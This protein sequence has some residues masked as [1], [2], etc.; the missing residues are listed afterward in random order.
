MTG[1]RRRARILPMDE[2]LDAF[3]EHLRLTRGASEHTLR[4]YSS[5]VLA[6]IEFARESGGPVDQMLVRRYLARLHKSGL[7][8]SSM[9][10]KLAAIR[11]FYG[12]LLRRGVVETDP[13]EGVR[14]PRLPRGLP[15]TLLEDQIESLMNAPDPNTPLGLRDRAILE[16]LYATGLRV[17][18]LLGLT[19][20]DVNGGSD[21]IRVIGKRNK[22]RIVLLGSKARQALDAYLAYGRP[23]LAAKTPRS[24]SFAKEKEQN[25]SAPTNEGAEGVNA[26][27]LG[28]RGTPLVASSVRRIVDKHVE[29]VSKSLKISPH[30]LRHS[31][32]THLMDH[33]ADLRSVQELLGHESLA[34]TQVYT[35]VSRERLKAVYDL[36]HPR[37]AAGAERLER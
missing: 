12:Y 30:T 3:I 6:F 18:E 10:R 26:L 24:L 22:E 11:A 5:D 2:Y 19:V 20:D 9:V 16:T 15:K 34:T 7:A 21:E 35:H 23:V 1:G 17:S 4:A 28:H 25:T 36:A 31:F 33:G 8:K 14:G 32:A 27:F 37:A 13:T 29:A